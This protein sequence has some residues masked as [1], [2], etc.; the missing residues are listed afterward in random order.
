MKQL[1]VTFFAAFFIVNFSSYGQSNSCSK[2]YSTVKGAKFTYTNYNRN[3]KKEGAISLEVVKVE[4]KGDKT[5]ARMKM[6]LLNKKG[7]ETN[8]MEYGFTCEGDMVKIDYKSLM[9]ADMINQMGSTGQVKF[10]GTDIELP[11]DL[12]VGQELADARVNMNIDMGVT[13]MSFN[14]ETL[15]R[16]IERKEK[17]TTSAGTFDCFLLTENHVL[18]MPMGGDQNSKSET[19]IAEGIGMVKQVTYGKH[20]DVALTSELTDYSQ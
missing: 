1:L 4:N 10:S 18:T 9:P 8:T 12:K 7:K 13:S 11:N 14:V 17:I 2:Y 3:D 20:G 16:K 6:R 15:D 19:W 5:E